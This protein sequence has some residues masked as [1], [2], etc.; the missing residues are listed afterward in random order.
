MKSFLVINHIQDQ[1][2]RKRKR[3]EKRQNFGP[4]FDMQKVYL[5]KKGVSNHDGVIPTNPIF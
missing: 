5:L 4:H 3:D 1:F 2:L